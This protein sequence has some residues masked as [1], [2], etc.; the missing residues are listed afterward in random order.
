MESIIK[1]AVKKY[2]K[3]REALV[4]VLREIV[5]Q[6]K[7]LS[8]DVLVSVAREFNLSTAQVYGTASFYSFLPTTP[9]GENVIRVC[10]TVVCDMAGKKELVSA[11]EKKLGVKMGGTTSDGKFTLL[12]TNC[13]GQCDNGPAMLINDRVYTKL[14]PAGA[15][16]AI[17]NF[18][19]MA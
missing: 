10:K 12:E 1:E 17:D 2:G 16:E 9:C 6:K 7:Y 13:L 8:E 19:G 5:K 14:T 4:S 3:D 11:I 15:V 18:F